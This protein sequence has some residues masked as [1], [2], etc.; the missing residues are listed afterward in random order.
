HHDSHRRAPCC[1][2]RLWTEEA[3]PSSPWRQPT[4]PKIDTSARNFSELPHRHATPCNHTESLVRSRGEEVTG[5]RKLEPCAGAVRGRCSLEPFGARLFTSGVAPRA[6][7]V[8]LHRLPL[9]L[10]RTR[11]AIQPHP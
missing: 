5:A 1:W 7:T 4:P 9:V 2:F 10:S 3:R 8:H 11:R 6:T